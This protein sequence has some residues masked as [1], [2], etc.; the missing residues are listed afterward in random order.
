MSLLLNEYPP[1]FISKHIERFFEQNNALPVREHLDANQYRLMHQRLLYQHT[2]WEKILKSADTN[3]NH[4]PDAV[5]FDEDWNSNVMYAPYVFET[6]PRLA[7]R[8]E[9][10]EWWEHYY[11]SPGS[12]VADATIRFAIHSNRTLRSLLI[13]KKPAKDILTTSNMHVTHVQPLPNEK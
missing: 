7:S 13:H 4:I 12:R 3:L 8:S 5:R 11:R 10:R 2:R 6:S 9:F 1:V